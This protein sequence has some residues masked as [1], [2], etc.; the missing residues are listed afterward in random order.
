MYAGQ[1]VEGGPSEEVIQRPKHPY[2]QLLLSAAPAPA[3]VLATMIAG[4]PV[5]LAIRERPGDSQ[6]VPG[7]LTVH[8]ED[9]G[10]HADRCFVPFAAEAEFLLVIGDTCDG[11]R[12]ALVRRDDPAVTLR[13]HDEVSR[14]ELYAVRFTGTPV[15]SWFDGP[16]RG[17]DRW[18]AA[19]AA[20][21]IRHAAY[22]VGLC[23]GALDLTVAHAK[24]RRQFGQPIGRFQAVALRLAATATRIQAARV[25]TYASAWEYDQGHDGRL[26]AARTLA[27]VADTARETM[28]EV[29]Q[30]HGAF[31]TTE[32]SDAQ[33]FYRRAGVDTPWLGS[34]TQLRA[35][36]LS[37]MTD[38]IGRSPAE[39]NDEAHPAWM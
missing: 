37:F 5:A 4:A 19:L 38:R 1:M 29:M 11:I 2:T 13:R 6:A 16:V 12:M 10:I 3:D 8:G 27:L 7:R 14:G 9:G 15:T 39:R 25:L 20:A 24:T 30:I 26:D 31:G 21:R 22:L 18:Q 28:T 34:P 33:L 23:T 35:E 17:A 36:V 32:E